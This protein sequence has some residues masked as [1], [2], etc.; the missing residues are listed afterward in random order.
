MAACTPVGLETYVQL[1]ATRLGLQREWLSFLRDYPL[2][3]APVFTESPPEPGL[4]SR[5]PAAHARVAAA[6]RMCSVTSLLGLPAVAVPTSV[7]EGLPLGTRRIARTC[8]WKRPRRSNNA[9]ARSLRSIHYTS[10]T[11]PGGECD[12]EQCGCCRALFRRHPE[13]WTPRSDRGRVRPRLR[14]PHRSAEPASGSSERTLG[15]FAI[16]F[17]VPRPS[18]VHSRHD[19]V[20]GALLVQLRGVFS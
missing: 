7:A 2:V 16:S 5:G 15:G 3:L 6:M 18:G 20:D 4:E 9:V 10:F 13:S 1:S 12:V 17:R 19:S 14:G 8:A 11:I